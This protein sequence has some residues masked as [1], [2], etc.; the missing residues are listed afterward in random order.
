MASLIYVDTHVATWLYAGRTD[1]FPD[2]ALRTIRTKQLVASPMV[3][4]ELEYLFET[5][6]TA[7]PG[8]TV[9]EALQEDIDLRHCDLPFERVIKRAIAQTWTRD[10]FDRI[11]VGQA[12][13]NGAP[14][15]TKD[16]T[17][18]Q[19]YE[20]AFWDDTASN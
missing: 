17:L 2:L 8:L 16:G 9:F 12:A 11:I 14:L 3:L 15:L 19:H 10:P 5:G 7:Q 1:L 6:R 18:R 13:V 4:L 20:H